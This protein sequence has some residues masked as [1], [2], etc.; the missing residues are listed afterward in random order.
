[1]VPKE[2]IAIQRFD[3]VAPR[4]D[5][6]GLISHFCLRAYLPQKR[7]LLSESDVFYRS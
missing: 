4:R 1:M 5:C 7:N 2:G 6:I 3:T